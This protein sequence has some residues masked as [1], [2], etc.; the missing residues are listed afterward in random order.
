MVYIMHP[1]EVNYEFDRLENDLPYNKKLGTVAVVGSYFAHGACINVEDSFAYKLQKMTGRKVY[2]F[3]VHGTGVA[4]VLYQVQNGFFK[5]NNVNPEYVVLVLEPDMFQIM[6]KCFMTFFHTM[7]RYKV[8]KY[9]TV[10]NEF[11]PCDVNFNLSDNMKVTSLMI[12][13]NDLR[14]K[15]IPFNNK[16]DY[17]KKY[18]TEIKLSLDEE[19]PAAKFVVVV[20][21][22]LKNKTDRWSEIEK[23]GIK[24]IDFSK[25]EYD[26]L[27]EEKYL[28]AQQ[29][30]YPNGLAWDY[31]LPT[32]IKKSGI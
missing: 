9:H 3:G 5:K 2:N 17:M 8:L 26:F 20:Y 1:V 11:V 28:D 22:S 23:E 19:Y 14:I 31:L 30:V 32:I 12:L 18:L 10:D 13:L 7:E 6:Y 21:P 27:V 4:D 15:Y 16:F 24:V 29:Y 25:E